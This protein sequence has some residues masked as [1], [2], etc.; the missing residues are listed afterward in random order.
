MRIAHVAAGTPPAGLTRD[1][2]AQWR[3]AETERMHDEL[4]RQLAEFMAGMHEIA[5]RDADGEALH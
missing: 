2:W 3:A 1:E 4:L 5:V